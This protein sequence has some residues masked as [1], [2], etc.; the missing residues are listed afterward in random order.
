MS[1]MQRHSQVGP[2]NQKERI[3]NIYL[4]YLVFFILINVNIL[5][6]AQKALD[7]I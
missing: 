7:S 1:C 6:D 2:K 4:L 3:F 5:I